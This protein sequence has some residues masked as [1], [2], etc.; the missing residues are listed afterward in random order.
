MVHSWPKVGARSRS[1]SPRGE[2]ACRK[3]GACSSA[4]GAAVMPAAARRAARTPFWAARPA[5]HDL[6]IEPKFAVSPAAIDA[7]SP[8]AWLARSASSRRSLA[9]AAA[10]ATVPNTPVGCQPLS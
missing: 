9:A 3:P 7:A 8:M 4:S 2:K 1:T 10:A 6:A 5:T